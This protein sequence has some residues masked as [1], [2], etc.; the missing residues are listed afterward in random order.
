MD[1]LVTSL[2]RGLQQYMVPDV[3]DFV[4]TALQHAASAAT[5]TLQPWRTRQTASPPSSIAPPAIQL[6]NC[7]ARLPID[8]TRLAVDKQFWWRTAVEPAPP[9]SNRAGTGTQYST[10]AFARLAPLRARVYA[11]SPYLWA[12]AP[13][14]RQETTVTELCWHGNGRRPKLEPVLVQ[15]AG[16]GTVAGSTPLTTLLHCLF[17]SDAGA[18]ATRLQHVPQQLQALACSLRLAWTTALGHRQPTEVA[19]VLATVVCCAQ[20]ASTATTTASSSATGLSSSPSTSPSPSASPRQRAWAAAAASLVQACH[21]HTRLAHSCSGC[22]EV[23]SRGACSQLPLCFDG[24]ACTRM[25][26]RLCSSVYQGQVGAAGRGAHVGAGGM[27]VQKR[28]S[29]ACARVA[30]VAGKLGDCAGAGCLCKVD[31][32]ALLAQVAQWCGV[33]L[34]EVAG[35]GGV[36]IVQQL[37]QFVLS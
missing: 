30:H 12:D 11:L 9:T 1:Q 5:A 37:L 32:S 36:G 15:R 21:V 28:V 19:A 3:P 22:G 16:A 17:G 20:S 35:G 25:L 2:E 13:A 31:Q 18:V 26:A 8:A 27:L 10:P 24:T 6:Q 33:T 14:Q 23:W 29:D 7:T 34:D 4:A